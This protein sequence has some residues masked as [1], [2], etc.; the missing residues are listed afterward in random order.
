LGLAACFNWEIDSFNFNGAYLNSEL[1]ADEEIYMQEPPG[2]EGQGVDSVK[3]LRKLLYGLKQAGRKWYDTLVRALTDL[4]FQVTQADPG[5]FYM[6]RDHHILILVMHVDDCIMTGSS[7]TLIR[8]YKKKL[9]S[10]YELTD[11]R[12]VNWLLGIKIT[13]NREQQT[14]LLSQRS[15]IDSIIKCFGLEDV[16]TYTTPMVLGVIYSQSDCPTMPAE[17]EL[18]KTVPYREAIGSLM[19][20]SVA[21]QPNITFAVSTLSQF[22]ENPGELHWATVKQ[23]FRY[24]SGTQDLEL[25]YGGERHDLVR[26]TDVD[27]VAQE[28]WH[29]ISG[30]IFILDVGAV[31]WSSQKQEL[32]TLSTT[33]AEYVAATHASKEALWLQKLIRE[34]FPLMTRPMMLYCDNQAMLRLIEDDNYHAQTKHIDVHYHFIWDITKC[35]DIKTIYCPTNQM[36]VDILTK[37]LPKWKV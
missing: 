15:Y 19:Y 36:V 33:E 18:M 26:Y 5:V 14:I 24:L 17:V 12:P 29:A 1:D 3:H 32:V 34:L 28:H 10:R 31:S 9:H 2:Y 7:K 27:G 21:T 4:G 35:G 37:A 13:R 23:I 16:K 11:L 20:A 8:V 22:L 25:T 6:W 30:H